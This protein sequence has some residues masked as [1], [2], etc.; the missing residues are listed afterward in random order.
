[1]DEKI[2]SFRIDEATA[3]LKEATE[4][5][6]QLEEDNKVKDK[7]VE[8]LV[9]ACKELREE[10]HTVT[11]GL[12]A[13]KEERAREVECWKEE[14]QRVESRNSE[15]VTVLRRRNAELESEVPHHSSLLLYDTIYIYETM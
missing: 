9:T 2:L 11:S 3:K 4:R 6:Q 7:E 14:L 5:C 8:R 10:R 12:K 15:E 13:M 1:M